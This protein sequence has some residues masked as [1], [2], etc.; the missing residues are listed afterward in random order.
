NAKANA[1]HSRD[2]NGFRFFMTSTRTAPA[3]RPNMASEMAMNAKWYHIVTLK[4]RVRNSS[5]CS[6]DN[7]VRKRPTYVDAL[8]FLKSRDS[9]VPEGDT[10]AHLNDVQRLTL[11]TR[12]R[13]TTNVNTRTDGAGRKKL[14]AATVVQGELGSNVRGAGAPHEK[15][16]RPGGDIGLHERRWRL[17]QDIRVVNDHFCL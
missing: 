14:Q 11:N 15:R 8:G 12:H 2:T 7:V 13:I 9:S 1:D 10:Q 5:S 4:I 6:S 3:A 16:T 17:N